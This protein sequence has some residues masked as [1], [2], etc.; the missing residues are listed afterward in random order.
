[1]IN[2][3][4]KLKSG[5]VLRGLVC[6]L[7]CA[8]ALPWASAQ[9]AEESSATTKEPVIKENKENKDGHKENKDGQAKPKIDAG[10]KVVE[11]PNIVVIVSDDGGW[12]DF[13]FNGAEDIKTPEI[14]KVAAAGRVF[15]AG[16][17]TGIVC[18]PSRAGLLTGRHQCRFGHEFNLVG[19]PKDKGLPL[20]ETTLAQRLAKLG[21]ATA[22]FGKWHLGGSGGY[23][24]EKR[25]FEYSY[26]FLGGSRAYKAIP[27]DGKDT[28]ATFRRN[29]VIVDQEKDIYVTDVIAGE[30][31]KYIKSSTGDKPFFL[32]VAFNCPHSPMQA[33]PGYEEQFSSITN[34]QRRILAAMQKS[35]DEGVG[36]IVAALKEK[37]VYDNTLI[38]F[39]NDNG[40]G[41]YSKFDNGGFRN[42]K[43]SLFEGGCRVAFCVSW[44]KVLKDTGGYDLP[45]SSMDIAATSLCA[46]GL[47]KLPEELEGTNLVP[48]L[49]GEKT[50]APHK[51]LC[52]RNGVAQSVR[53]GDWK[54]IQIEGKPQFLFNLKEDPYEKE[55][56]V[57]DE[58]L[59]SKVQ[60]LQ[61][62]YAV[63]NGRNVEALWRAE[64]GGLG[65]LNEFQHRKEAPYERKDM[66]AAMERLKGKSTSS[67]AKD[68]AKE[69]KAE[70]GADNLKKEGM[71]KASGGRRSS[72]V[73]S[74]RAKKAQAGESSGAAEPPEEE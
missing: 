13:G 41:T 27:A 61:K 60:E 50:D 2:H 48:Y 72:G 54:L 53:Q 70:D 6:T 42:N 31:G 64:T 25:G 45:V 20:T 56:L 73:N 66:Q 39:V 55:N 44:P 69:T 32:Y 68:D 65:T 14:D 71:K 34:K 30:A 57:D 51:A 16:Y 49:N 24:P 22:A 7:L 3:C 5:L 62:T 1:M 46:A 21:Y 8:L 29:G 26:T 58:K 28:D 38:W 47:D 10:D 12:R 35:L 17:V 63:W 15:T 23:G 74:R 33:K 18:S 43:G 59:V 40:G 37:G 4:F 52:W 9:A 11:R 67:E 19:A 36:S